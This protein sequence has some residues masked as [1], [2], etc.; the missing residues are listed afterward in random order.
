MCCLFVRI[1]CAGRVL[2][3]GGCQRR[4]PTVYGYDVSVLVEGVEGDGEETHENKFVVLANRPEPIRPS[5]TPRIIKCECRDE[6]R[7]ALT[8]CYNATFP[9]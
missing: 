6:R 7:V 2:G 4:S 9:G 5:I 3:G 8:S 1:R